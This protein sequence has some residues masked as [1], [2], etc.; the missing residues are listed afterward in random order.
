MK[1]IVLGATLAAIVGAMSLSAQAADGTIT[2]AG[3]VT[4]STCSISPISGGSSDIVVNVGSHGKGSL[5]AGQS[6]A[7]KPINFKIVGDATCQ[8]G[9]A[10]IS[11]GSINVDP[12]NGHLV[13]VSAGGSNVQA[14]LL[15]KAGNVMDLRT[16]QSLVIATG[17]NE[18]NW[19]TRLYAN[20]ADA[21]VGDFESSVVLQIEQN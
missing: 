16:P 3:E 19:H 12:A 21:T 4:D 13:N 6:T 1:K 7:A 20:G 5:K 9:N 17:D 2:I 14:Q 11:F 8:A 18:L 15:D 10:T